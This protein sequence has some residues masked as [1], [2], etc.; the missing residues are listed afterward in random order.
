[1]ATPD[2]NSMSR[3]ELRQYMLDN[4]NDKAAFEF[5]LDKFRN[6]N[7]PVYPAPQSL[8]DMSYLQKIILQH[9]ADK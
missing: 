9:Q 8:E 3:E 5:Y 4:R 6:P 2:F 1:M 7:N